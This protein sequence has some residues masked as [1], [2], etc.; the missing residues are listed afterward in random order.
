MQELAGNEVVK[1]LF[2]NLSPKQGFSLFRL[3]S[4]I[5]DA[6]V[7][8]VGAERGTAKAEYPAYFVNYVIAAYAWSVLNKGADLDKMYSYL[9]DVSNSPLPL[10]EKNSLKP[11]VDMI[12]KNNDNIKKIFFPICPG[13]ALITNGTAIANNVGFADCVETAIRQFLAM[14]LCKKDGKGERFIDWNILPE[15]SK[16]RVALQG[17]PDTIKKEGVVS[18]DY[19]MNDG[20]REVRDWWATCV[21]NLNGIDYN[22]GTVELMPGYKNALKVICELLKGDN[23]RGDLA[24]IIGYI[25]NNYTN[26]V[27]ECFEQLL[28]LQPGIKLDKESSFTLSNN[29]YFGNISFYMEDSKEVNNVKL[30]FSKGH[31][32]MINRTSRTLGEIPRSAVAS[33][34][35]QPWLQQLYINPN[36]P[37]YGDTILPPCSLTVV[38]PFPLL[39][40]AAVLRKDIAQERRRFEYFEMLTK[41]ESAMPGIV[42]QLFRKEEMHYTRGS[43][44]LGNLYEKGVEKTGEIK[45]NI[46]QMIG[47]VVFAPITQDMSVYDAS[48][49]MEKLLMYMELSEENKKYVRKLVKNNDSLMG[50]CFFRFLL[51]QTEVADSI[52]R[53]RILNEKKEERFEQSKKDLVTSFRYINHFISNPLMRDKITIE[54]NAG[55]KIKLIDENVFG[56]IFP[57]I[58][59]M[60]GNDIENWRLFFSQCRIP[61]DFPWQNM[62]KSK[63]T[64]IPFI[65]APLDAD[66]IKLFF[67][68]NSNSWVKSINYE[69]EFMDEKKWPSFDF[70]VGAHIIRRYSQENHEGILKRIKWKDANPTDIAQFSLFPNGKYGSET[71]PIPNSTV[72]RVFS[73][74]LASLMAESS[75]SIERK[76]EKIKALIVGVGCYYEKIG[77][78]TIPRL[79]EVYGMINDSLFPGIIPEVV[80]ALD[81]TECRGGVFFFLRDIRKRIRETRTDNTAL[82]EVVD[83]AIKGILEKTSLSIRYICFKKL[84]LDGGRE[85]KFVISLLNGDIAKHYLQEKVSR[86]IMELRA[87]LFSNVENILN[88]F[89]ENAKNIPPLSSEENSRIEEALNALSESMNSVKDLLNDEQKNKMNNYFGDLKESISALKVP[90]GDREIKLIENNVNIFNSFM[91]FPREGGDNTEEEKFNLMM[92][93]L[94]ILRE[95]LL[96]VKVSFDKSDVKVTKKA[97]DNSIDSIC[98]SA[99]I[100]LS[101]GEI[102]IMEKVLG[103]KKELIHKELEALLNNN[104][105]NTAIEKGLQ[106]FFLIT[107]K[108]STPEIRKMIEEIVKVIE[109]RQR[110]CF[111][112]RCAARSGPPPFSF[113]RN[114]V[115]IGDGATHEAI[116]RKII[117]K[118][119]FSFKQMQQ[120]LG[121]EAS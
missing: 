108:I 87:R 97:L 40:Y 16:L 10:S 91:W 62:S 120:R 13:D 72:E 37:I 3:I 22:R 31:G 92:E 117:E 46:L 106:T 116:E 61:Y 82:L 32:Q 102:E 17:A 7:Q 69:K 105:I 114:K 56:K 71:I 33:I 35:K 96:T 38:S 47:S 67:I 9:K 23:P 34:M 94:R 88:A 118:I 42:R 24:E 53:R 64:T 90:F 80:K 27:K 104:A 119:I 6:V 36:I 8:E 78:D 59:K 19:L 66:H 86:E 11:M 57:S 83:N 107:D 55:L 14:L 21:S 4:N 1:K 28:R 68:E 45:G 70:E 58:E 73:K 77:L 30:Y 85:D 52:L 5:R 43:S 50:A 74:Y 75:L 109:K 29:E 12:L 100:Q 20:S 76:V 44:P 41:S 49:S 113:I 60:T 115:Y 110:L 111:L 63:E 112:E 65:L 81:V 39:K 26:K 51:G 95:V 89:S 98:N 25:E 84:L 15:A 79:E 54:E 48:V 2:P 101:D 18:A 99:D 103:A 93:K 121:A